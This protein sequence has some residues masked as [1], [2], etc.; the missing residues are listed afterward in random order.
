[1]SS[2][3]RYAAWALVIV[4]HLSP[5]SQYL[6]LHQKLHHRI[7]ECARCDALREAIEKTQWRC[8]FPKSQESQ[9]PAVVMETAESALPAQTPIVSRRT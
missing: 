8:R 3:A 1:M 4:F 5:R 7:A 2:R 6:A 9:D